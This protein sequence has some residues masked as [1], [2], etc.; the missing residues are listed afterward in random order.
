MGKTSGLV[1]AY[2]LLDFSTQRIVAH[3]FSNTNAEEVSVEVVSLPYLLEL[4]EKEFIKVRVPPEHDQL[5]FSM[6]VKRITVEILPDRIFAIA[7]EGLKFLNEAGI[8]Y[9]VVE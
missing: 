2:Q 9:E 6:L 8:P 3:N 4:R 5:A 1:S 7:R